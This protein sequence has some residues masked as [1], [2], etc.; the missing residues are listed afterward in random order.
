MSVEGW[1]LQLLR[2]C[3]IRPEQLMLLLQPL[4]GSMPTTDAEFNQLCVQ[5]HLHG[6]V[7]GTLPRCCRDP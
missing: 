2:T 5:L 6:H 1:S 7:M 4:G 3:K